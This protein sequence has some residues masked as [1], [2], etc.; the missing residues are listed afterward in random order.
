[1]ALE[2]EALT[3]AAGPRARFVPWVLAATAAALY[4]YRLGDAPMRVGGDEALFAINAHAIATAGC[5]LDGHLLPLFFKVDLKTWYQPAPMALVAVI[6][7]VLAPLGSEPRPAD[8]L[9]H[10]AAR[11]RAHQSGLCHST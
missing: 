6:S 5:D 1:M 10:C 2:T 3:E 4:F 9:P 7:V 8:R 11:A